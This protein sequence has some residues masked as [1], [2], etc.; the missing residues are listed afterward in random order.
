MLSVMIGST[1]TAVLAGTIATAAP[2]DGGPLKQIIVERT[3]TVIVADGCWPSLTGKPGS[4]PE[5]KRFFKEFTARARR[6][7]RKAQ[8]TLGLNYLD[9]AMPDR[10]QAL[11]WF[12]KAARAGDAWSQC[13][14]GSLYYLRG[15]SKNEA[16]AFMW[17]KLAAEQVGPNP[18][19]AQPAL[20]A[21]GVMYADGRGTR[22]DP[23]QAVVWLRRAA[24]KGDTD[25][26]LRLAY[27]YAMGR[28]VPRDLAKGKAYVTE[29]LSQEDQGDFHDKL[30]QVSDW[31]MVQ[32][33]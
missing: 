6:G 3:E 11:Y 2:M 26:L 22:A 25:A 18:S 30:K 27:M 12:E 19:E 5:R 9:S 33:N 4:G 15:G 13:M 23:T 1:L 20:T 24:N 28:G 17:Y 10:I 21:L 32:P 16:R 8:S 29:A 7:D 14:A 31:L